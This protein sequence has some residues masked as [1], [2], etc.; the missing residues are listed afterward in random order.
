MIQIIKKKQKVQKDLR[1][2]KLEAFT[3]FLNQHN[4]QNL[5]ELEK[6]NG[7]EK[8]IYLGVNHIRSLSK[9]FL[10][11]LSPDI[12][13]MEFV[14]SEELLKA[15]GHLTPIRF[16]QLF[17]IEKRYDGARYDIKDYFY[18]KELMDKLPEN[19]PIGDFETMFHLLWDYQNIVLEEFLLQYMG[20]ISL[21]RQL[22]G[23]QDPL[24]EFLHKEGVP[25]YTCHEKEGYISNNLTG[26]VSKL[27][28]AKKRRP[29][30]LKVVK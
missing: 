13:G 1:L 30:F 14:Y 5:E 9:D 19:Q 25:T 18:T 15:M 22:Q 2:V 26:E 10:K 24:V 3:R 16:Q 29:K 11:G 4:W 28:K 27:K 21:L 23:G 7:L 20:I 12:I 8:F 17:P 6:E